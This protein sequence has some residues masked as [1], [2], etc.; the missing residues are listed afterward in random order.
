MLD[1]ALTLT[2]S[3]PGDRH[4][5]AQYFSI[6]TAPITTTI[7]TPSVGTYVTTDRYY[8]PNYTYSTFDRHYYPSD[9]SYSR[10]TFS[11]YPDYYRQ[12]TVIVNTNPVYY[13]PSIGSQCTTAIVGS[14][15][16][17]A[18]PFDRYSGMPCR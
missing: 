10:V 7:V 18:V 11:N 16:P 15:I 5:I 2:T 13:P 14:P 1:L 6:Q 8:H 9:R 3:M 4:R 12:P 17:S